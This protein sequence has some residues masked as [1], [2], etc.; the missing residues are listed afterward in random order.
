VSRQYNGTYYISSP[1]TNHKLSNEDIQ[2][3][4]DFVIESSLH[5]QE[6]DFTIEKG[7]APINLFDL[8]K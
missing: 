2:Y 3:C 6:F 1:S 8:F 5:L 4:Y 7:A